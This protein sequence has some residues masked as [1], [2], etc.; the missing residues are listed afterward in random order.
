M[1]TVITFILAILCSTSIAL[2]DTYTG[3][4]GDC[5]YTLDTDEGTLVISGTGA[6]EDYE[7]YDEYSSSNAPW[8]NLYIKT[9]TIEDGVTSIGDY[10]FYFCA[11]LTSVTIGSGVTSIGE[12]AFSW[13]WSLKSVTF[14]DNSA[15]TSIG[16]DA[17]Y[18]CTLTSITIPES[19]TNI[20][21]CAFRGCSSLTSITV[22]EGNTA[23]V[24]VDGVL[25]TYDMTTL[26]CYPA[27]KTDTSFIIPEGVTSIDLCA[28]DGCESLTSVT[29]SDSVTSIGDYAFQACTSLTSVTIG[30]G[31]TSIGEYAFCWC[32]SLKSVTFGD[33]S[34]LTS[35][36]SDAFYYCTSITS[37]TIP[38][39]VTSIGD[40]AFYWC[41]SLDSII[42]LNTTPPTI[43]SSTFS[44]QYETATLYATSTDYATADYWE[45]FTNIVYDTSGN[46]ISSVAASTSAISAIGNTIVIT[47]EAA[48]TA[49]VY[50][51]AG[52]LIVKQAVSAG[53]TSIDMPTGGVYIVALADGTKAKVLVK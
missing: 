45:N 1:R 52:Q 43:Y 44:D 4:T 34:A 30:S 9:V 31:V 3:T 2:A 17:F 19:V 5:T 38:E 46:A 49:Q 28:F 42:S 13:C 14:G 16:S 11:N 25:Y 37:I 53:E 23:Y 41:S 35:I 18:A 32:W 26:V 8:N 36:G 40:Y 50:S 20:G 51:L 7:Y 27:G 6:M 33:N 22:S 24:S 21:E 15:L 12:W 10:A 39:S 47:T 29:I 48:Q